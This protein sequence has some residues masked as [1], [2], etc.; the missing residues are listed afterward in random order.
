MNPKNIELG[1][2][3]NEDDDLFGSEDPSKDVANPKLSIQIPK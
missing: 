3:N 1:A 2:S